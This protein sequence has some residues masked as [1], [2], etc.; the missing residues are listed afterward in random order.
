MMSIPQDLFYT[1]THEWV[2]LEDGIATIGI[3]DFAQSQLSDLTF[4]ELPEVGTEFDGGDE[5]AVVESVKAAA[6]VYA[7]IAGEVVEV[8]ED[9]EDSPELINDDA[10]GK[11]WLFKIRVV[12]ESDVDSLLDP[13]TYED[14]CPTD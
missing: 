6:D 12:D 5:A 4:V 2:S 8:N 13:E 11:G 7:P 9:L 14:L 10:F 1:K 3:T